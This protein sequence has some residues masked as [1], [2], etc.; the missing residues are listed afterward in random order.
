MVQQAFL[1]TELSL[2]PLSD[3]LYLQMLKEDDV[4]FVSIDFASADSTNHS[5]KK[6]CLENNCNYPEHVQVF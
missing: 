4:V 1:A 6:N 3:I 2:H 5:W